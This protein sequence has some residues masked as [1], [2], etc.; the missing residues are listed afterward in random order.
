MVVCVSRYTRE[1]LLRGKIFPKATRVILNGADATLFKILPRK[2][3][4]VVIRA[5]PMILKRDPKAHYLIAGMP[6]KQKE[7]ERLALNLGVH[8]HVH[9]LGRVD[10]GNLIRCLNVCDIFVMMSRHTAREFEGYGIAVVEAALCNKPSIVSDESGLSEAIKDGETG[11]CVPVDDGTTTAE[12]VLTLLADEE[13]RLKMGKA[14]RQRA[15][16][17]QTWAHRVAEYDKFLRELLNS[18]SLSSS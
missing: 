6:D 5:L 17:E 1:R 7:F 12:R 18:V 11:F 2:G 8:D 14:A 3:Q 13:L 10:K 4:E 9:F 15:L 16:S